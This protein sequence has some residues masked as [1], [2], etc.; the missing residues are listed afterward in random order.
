[1]LVEQAAESFFLWR[2]VR[3]DAQA[4]YARPRA[5]RALEDK[6]PL[7]EPL[8]SRL[9]EVPKGSERPMRRFHRGID[10]GFRCAAETNPASKAEGAK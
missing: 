3:P 2:G 8:R 7:E 5:L 9:F 6:G 1:M 4:V 10:V